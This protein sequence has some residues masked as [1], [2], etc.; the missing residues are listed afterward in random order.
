MPEINAAHITIV[1]YHGDN[2]IIYNICFKCWAFMNELLV[3]E[4]VSMTHIDST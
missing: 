4:F 3:A 1:M 2:S